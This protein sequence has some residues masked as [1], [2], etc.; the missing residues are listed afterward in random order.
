MKLFELYQTKQ[1]ELDSLLSHS[2]LCQGVIFDNGKVSVC[3]LNEPSS[4]VLWEC[5]DDF[6]KVSGIINRYVK[7]LN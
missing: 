4:V 2:L 5:M 1:S 7:Y 3:W 6:K